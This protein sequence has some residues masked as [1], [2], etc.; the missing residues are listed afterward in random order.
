MPTKKELLYAEVENKIKSRFANTVSSQEFFTAPSSYFSDKDFFDSYNKIQVQDEEVV[1]KKILE[2]LY[3]QS[4]EHTIVDNIVEV[5]ENNSTNGLD[6]SAKL[7]SI[8]ESGIVES[9]KEGC[10]N[11]M[12]DDFSD[13]VWK[14]IPNKVNFGSTIISILTTLFDSLTQSLPTM[15]RQNDDLSFEL[16]EGKV[17]YNQEYNDTYLATPKRS[18][19]ALDPKADKSAMRVSKTLIEGFDSYND[20]EKSSAI[21]DKILENIHK[22]KAKLGPSHKGKDSKVINDF[23]MKVIEFAQKE[24]GVGNAGEDKWHDFTRTKQVLGFT[25]D[26]AKQFSYHYQ[27]A[28]KASAV[29]TGRKEN[30]KTG[31]AVGARLKRI[32]E[33][34]NEFIKDGL[35]SSSMTS[36]LTI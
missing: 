14:N 2:V 10:I 5:I 11:Y 32:P 8:S 19:S 21:I 29:Y 30:L 3:Q 26:D 4:W 18:S 35:E 12:D 24:G 20:Q 33:D 9:P 1:S 31:P 28:A 25:F 17:D 34:L 13:L 27:Q 22:A 6:L 15:P 16:K 23:V 7:K 36:S